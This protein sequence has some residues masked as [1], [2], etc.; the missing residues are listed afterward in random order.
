VGVPAHDD[1]DTFALRIGFHQMDV[2]Q[3]EKPKAADL[4]CPTHRE[5]FR[6]DIP[7][8]VSSNGVDR[9]DGAQGMQGLSLADVSRVEDQIDPLKARDQLRANEPVRVGDDS[10]GDGGTWGNRIPLISRVRR[11]RANYAPARPDFAPHFGK[12]ES[13]AGIPSSVRQSPRA[14]GAMRSEFTNDILIQV[15][16]IDEAAS[17]YSDILGL[18]VTRRELEM[19]SLKGP[20]L[21][22]FLFRGETLGP[23][24]EVLVAD[25]NQTKARLVKEGARV[26]REE[27]D[28]PRCYVRDRYG[29]IYNLRRK[30]G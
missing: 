26:M 27:P 6:P 11:H 17:F 23:V 24:L 18:E 3:D 25:V 5:A 10:D 15:P 8:D 20:S 22:L 12:I 21:N 28:V 13:P 14:G 2:V 16:D 7:I 30:D 4:D 29:L 9:R 1:V 19:I